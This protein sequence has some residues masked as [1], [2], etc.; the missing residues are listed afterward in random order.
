MFIYIV[1]LLL[2]FLLIK[3]KKYT[4]FLLIS[5][6]LFLIGFLRSDSVGTDVQ[7]YCSIID[8]ISAESSPAD[9]LLLMATEN[10]EVGFTYLIVL[11]KHFSNDPMTFIRFAF[12]IY[13][14]GITI[15]IKKYSINPNLSYFVYYTL[16]FYFFSFNGVRQ[17]F[18]L[19]L[20]LL[21]LAKSDKFNQESLLKSFLVAGL[22]IVIGILFHKSVVLC[23]IIPFIIRYKDVRFFNNKF[24]IFAILISIVLSVF[25]SSFLSKV[26]GGLDVS[27][28][29][30]EKYSTYMERIAMENDFSFVSNILH[31]LFAIFL[32]YTTKERNPWL[33]IYTV[34]TIILVL[35]S[36]LSWLFLRVADNYNIFIALA[37]PSVFKEWKNNYR[38]YNIYSLVTYLYCFIL[39]FNRLLDDNGDVIPYEWILF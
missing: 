11:V 22:I 8:D 35:L 19:S 12:L 24:L 10:F 14:V 39:F 25:F 13:F 36:P 3:S 17:A 15:W 34:G 16:A 28:L 5:T 9:V 1:I 30:S 29:G 27:F 26:V 31:A 23:A 20:V 33:I 6:I 21:L 2:L 37:I 32:L 4:S 7:H 38:N 18:A